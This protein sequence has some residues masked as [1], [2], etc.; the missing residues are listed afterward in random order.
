MSFTITIEDF[1]NQFINGVNGFSYLPVWVS[2]KAYFTNDIVYWV[3][4][5]FYSSLIDGNLTAPDNADNWQ[6]TRANTTDF[7]TDSDIANAIA[8]A[9]V[10]F[11]E[12]LLGDDTTKRLV[13]SYL[14]AFYLV[15]DRKNAQGTSVNGW[16]ASSSIGSVSVSY[17]FPQ[18]MN[19]N[20]TYGIYMQNG[21]GQKYL[22]LIMP[23]L[24][25]QV[26]VCPGKTTVN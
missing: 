8:E 4:G 22:S 17:Q 7:I 10:N 11:P 16:L 14:A 12:R 23:Y 24:V 9:G 26:I 20:P 6:L 15:F 19:E 5:N 13:F 25:G 2:G 21:Y 3:D 18:W 1:K